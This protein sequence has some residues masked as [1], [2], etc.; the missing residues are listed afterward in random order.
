[1][2]EIKG[3]E[4]LQNIYPADHPS[5]FKE[6][7]FNAD[8]SIPTP[9]S[10]SDTAKTFRLVTLTRMAC[11]K[12]GREY[13]VRVVRVWEPC[14]FCGTHNE[15]CQCEKCTAPKI[16]SAIRAEIIKAQR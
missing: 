3:Q 8:L 1:M 16:Q 13:Q 7:I 6:L 10:P 12:C 11:G 15:K 4:H 9:A 2:S 5:E 14:R